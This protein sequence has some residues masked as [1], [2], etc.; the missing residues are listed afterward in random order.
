VPLI[1]DKN[2]GRLAYLTE[3]WQH[4][5]RVRD[6]DPFVTAHGGRHKP[7]EGVDRMAQQLYG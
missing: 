4:A 1:K 2:I 3:S 7:P 5:P 6:G